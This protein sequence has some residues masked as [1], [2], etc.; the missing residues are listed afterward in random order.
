MTPEEKTHHA[1]RP[2]DDGFSPKFMGLYRLMGVLGES[3]NPPRLNV[4]CV[5]V[6][7]CIN[8][9]RQ[10]AS[11]LSQVGPL[12]QKACTKALGV[13]K[14]LTSVLPKRLPPYSYMENTWQIP[15]LTFYRTMFNNVTIDKLCLLL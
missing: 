6:H 15:P 12:P 14:S 2:P 8:L 9:R 4:K 5:F 10:C 7:S 3:V 11:M 13:G 1:P